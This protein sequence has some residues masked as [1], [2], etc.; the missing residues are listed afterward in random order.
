MENNGKLSSHFSHI[1]RLLV[2]GGWKRVGLRFDEA[3][4]EFE[5]AWSHIYDEFGNKPQ[6]TSA[7]SKKLIASQPLATALVL[8][9]ARSD[10]VEVFTRF[11]RLL[12]S[13]LRQTEDLAGYPAVAAIPHV[14]AGFLYMAASVMALH[15][16]AWGIFEKLFT[17][18]FEWYHHSSRASFSYP[19]DLSRF[20]HSEALGRSAS[21]VHDFFR[22]E[23]AEPD[24]VAVTGLKGERLLDAYV[25]T[26]MLMSLKVAQLYQNEENVS[27]WPDFGRFYGDRI[28]RLLDRMYAESEY[29]RGILRAF[30]ED[31]KTFFER[32]NERLALIHS[33]FWGGSLYFYE[34]LGSWEPR[35]THA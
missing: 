21:K 4:R 25:Q 18:K 33:T 15:W 11:K 6:E 14:Q 31:P 23:L 28:T 8:S 26:Q 5:N 3:Q 13:M 24:F 1:S 30:G 16:E 12:E 10:S 35:E 20:F 22:T 32:L 2:R 17:G 7:A 19:F 29:A 27:I 34:S 9:M